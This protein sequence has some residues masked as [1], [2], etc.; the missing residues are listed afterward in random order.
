LFAGNEEVRGMSL[1]ERSLLIVNRA[2]GTGH[3]RATVE[4]LRE[5]LAG[6]L[7]DC[8]TLRVEIVEDHPSARA[9]VAEFL[10]AS[11][12]P[13]LVVAGGGSG[14]L[15]AV[16]EGLCE[17]GSEGGPPGRERV[18][19]G[20]LRMG[21]GNPL[22]RQFGVP[23]DPEAALRGIAENLRAGR[24]APCCVMRCEVRALD[25]RSETRY[26]ATMAGF[27]QFGRAPGD[28][29]R[30]HRRT[31]RPRA[32]M[33]RLSGIERINNV[34]YILALLIRSLSGAVLGRSTAEVVE[35]SAGDRR[36][37]L[38]LLAGVAMNFPIGEL[39]ID[40]G[41]RVEEEVLSLYLAPYTGRSSALRLV[42]APRRVFQ[43]AKMLRIEGPER[44]EIRLVDRDAAEFFL[45]EDPVT[46][47]GRLSLQVAGSLTFV[48]GPEYQFGAGSEVR[49]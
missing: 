28:L 13:A 25:G 20:A 3:G 26:A 23:R 47:H 36:V 14:T 39:P 1:V 41:T 37:R 27:G 32:V 43:S 45:D 7:G 9:C 22:A 6:S 42:L 12:A 4:K 21:S 11:G 33:A 40:P 10:A 5:T 8:V 15:R 16:I 30:W 19:V 17:E 18:L 34:E 38:P 2:S 31:A 44:V 46:F 24:S 35:V 29:E 49:A 48:P